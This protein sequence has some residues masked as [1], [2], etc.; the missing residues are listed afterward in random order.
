MKLVDLYNGQDGLVSKRAARCA[1]A[2]TTIKVLQKLHSKVDSMFSQEV[3]E[4]NGEATPENETSPDM[5]AAIKGA[6]GIRLVV[7]ECIQ[8][9]IMT[10]VADMEGPGL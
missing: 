4:N 1:S 2:V 9:M 10:I 3:R 8:S 7:L 5:A 6:K